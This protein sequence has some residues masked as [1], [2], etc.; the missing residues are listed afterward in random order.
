MSFC[1]KGKGESSPV[2]SPDKLSLGKQNEDKAQSHKSR[3]EF[4][5]ATDSRASQFTVIF[6]ICRG[7]LSFFFLL[8]TVLP[9]LNQAVV[10]KCCQQRSPHKSWCEKEQYS[11]TVNKVIV[12]SPPPGKQLLYSKSPIQYH[13]VTP[14]ERERNIH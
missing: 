6:L 7:V 9:P 2:F 5:C 11:A 1:C 10:C 4:L 12:T 13:G 3:G 8:T 14:E